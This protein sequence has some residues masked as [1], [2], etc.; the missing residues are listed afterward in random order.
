ML[1]LTD[2]L[3]SQLSNLGVL[4]V[5]CDLLKDGDREFYV[6]GGLNDIVN[7]AKKNNSVVYYAEVSF[8]ESNFEFEFTHPR[9]GNRETIDLAKIF[10]LSEF[11]YHKGETCFHVLYVPTQGFVAKAFSEGAPWFDKFLKVSEHVIGKVT[12]RLL[13]SS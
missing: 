9:T 12:S 8:D 5:E 10:D 3:A 13:Q 4:A 1:S 11:E 6:H 7:I 2:R